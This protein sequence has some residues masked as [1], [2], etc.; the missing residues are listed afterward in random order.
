M[1]DRTIRRE[2]SRRV[3]R[4]CRPLIIFRVTGVAIRRRS[5]KFSPDMARRTGY[6]HMCARQRKLGKRGVIKSR[7][8][9]VQHC[10]ALEA[11]FGERAGYVIGIGCRLEVLGVT[12]VAVHWEPL[13]FPSDVTGR[14]FQ[15]CVRSHESESGPR[16][17]EGCRQPSVSGMAG[18]TG[19]GESQGLVI[20]TERFCILIVLD[21]T[22]D[23]V[24]AQSLEL[25]HRRPHVAR[26]ALNRCVSPQERE[27]IPMLLNSL[28]GDVPSIHGVAL[29]AL[30]SELAAMQIRMTIRALCPNIA[31]HQ[32]EVAEP[33][34]HFPVHSPQREMCLVVIKFGKASDGL[35]TRERVTVLTTD[36]QWAVRIPGRAALMGLRH[37]R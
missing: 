37:T 26:G 3:I 33:A 25:A 20:E 16:V 31:E 34:V 24:G 7:S 8:L 29:L 12:T 32:F 22:G 35:P 14:A 10:V 23:A 21:V 1:A 11:I 5:G 4:S 9:P 27:A 28:H 18:F 36:V 13:E 2:S 6:C 15:L 19:R 17:I 30:G